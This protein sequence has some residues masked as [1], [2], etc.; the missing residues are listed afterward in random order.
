[1]IA[2][3]ANLNQEEKSAPEAEYAAPFLYFGRSIGSSAA[4]P[5]SQDKL[6]ARPR[7]LEHR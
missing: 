7:E 4:R 2:Q 1:V 6:K 3:Q 5:A